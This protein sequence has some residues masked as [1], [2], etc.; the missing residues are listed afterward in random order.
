MSGPSFEITPTTARMFITMANELVQSEVEKHIDGK[1]TAGQ[2]IEAIRLRADVINALS[3]GMR[4][5]GYSREMI[6]ETLQLK[7]H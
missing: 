2:I 6:N 4:E 1:A 5:A 3:H 7:G